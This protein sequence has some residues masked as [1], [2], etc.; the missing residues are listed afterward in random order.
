MRL[1]TLALLSFLLGCSPAKSLP[2]LSNVEQ[3]LSDVDRILTIA[4]ATWGKVKAFM[5][6]EAAVK[7]DR[8][9]AEKVRA[10]RDLARSL[11]DTMAKVKD[12]TATEEDAQAVFSSLKA[13]VKSLREFFTEFKAVGGNGAVSQADLDFA[14]DAFLQKLAPSGLSLDHVREVARLSTG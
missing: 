4:D 12:G 13:A 10:V 6:P 11:K 5:A 9:Y 14:V 2:D 7:Y 8:T 3:A 1:A